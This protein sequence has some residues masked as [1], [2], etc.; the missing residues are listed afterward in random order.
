MPYAS[1]E[2]V[3][4]KKGKRAKAEGN[5]SAIGAELEVD[6]E[7]VL[8]EIRKDDDDEQGEEEDS[9]GEEI[10]EVKTNLKPS[11]KPVKKSP[12]G[13]RGG[14]TAAASSSRGRGPGRK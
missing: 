4:G 1:A 6:E 7:G 2:T 12:A 8:K 9:G 3:A 13:K 11:S 10:N 5:T 14:K